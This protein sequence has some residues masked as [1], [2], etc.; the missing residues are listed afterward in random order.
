MPLPKVLLTR[1][2]GQNEVLA[3]ALKEAGI[4][5]AVVPVLEVNTD[6]E[7]LTTALRGQH[8]DWVVVTSP[9][10]ARTITS[11]IPTDTKIAVVGIQTA[12]ALDRKPDLVAEI[13]NAEGLVAA[14]PIANDA[15]GRVLVCQ[16]DLADDTVTSGIAAKGWT[17]VG[18]VTYSV[19]ARDAATLTREIENAGHI[20]AIVLASGSAARALPIAPIMPKVICIGPKTEM[21]AQEIGLSVAATAESQDTSGL[22]AAVLRAVR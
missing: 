12:D 11:K 19:S 10:G 18:I 4:E 13:T 9:N 1:A 7:A 3:T 6:N 2:A 22:T 8:Y 16:S 14:F 17:V 21:V 5:V 15:S 20:D